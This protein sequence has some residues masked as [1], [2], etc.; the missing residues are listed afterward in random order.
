MRCQVLRVR[1]RNGFPYTLPDWVLQP[2][3][4]LLGLAVGL[5]MYSGNSRA[6]QPGLVW[7]EAGRWARLQPHIFKGYNSQVVRVLGVKVLGSSGLRVF[8]AG[9]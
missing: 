3:M 2:F 5:F 9:R 8:G 1:F 4:P 6:Q 7:E